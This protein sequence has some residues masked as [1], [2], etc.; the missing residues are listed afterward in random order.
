MV[1]R[2]RDGGQG[3]EGSTVERPT[4]KFCQRTFTKESTLTSHICEQKR[5]W[6]AK[7]DK[8]VQLGFQAYL[9]FFAYTQPTAKAKTYDEFSESPYYTAFVKFG[10]Y[11]LNTKCVNTTAFIDW[12]ITKN[13]KLDKWATD[14]TYE[15]FLKHWIKHENH[16]DAIDR[17]VETMTEWATT[18][19]TSFN[20]YFKYAQ[21]S[22]IAHDLIRGRIS[23]WCIYCSQSGQDFLASLGADD[24][25]VIYDWIDPDY[26]GQ[27]IRTDRVTALEVEMVMKELKF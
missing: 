22:R 11:M 14:K 21:P 6:Q 4:C 20:H 5:R 10:R 15:E 1:E 3:S 16:L 12:V 7:N 17:T 19:E 9:R 27:K 8:W 18:R 24:L 26:W 13:K 23:P 2:L 25:T